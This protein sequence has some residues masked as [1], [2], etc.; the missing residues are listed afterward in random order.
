MSGNIVLLR[1]AL[2]KAGYSPELLEEGRVHEEGADVPWFVGYV[3]L[4]RTS[5]NA[6]VAAIDARS[7]KIIGRVLAETGAPVGLV[8]EGAD[9]VSVWQGGP[10]GA[11]RRGVHALSE[12]VARV[13]AVMAVASVD[14]AT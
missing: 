8:P 4:P 10:D 12:F 5:R 1:R 3:R 6:C 14:A 9:G 11:R 13:F 2:E 7:P